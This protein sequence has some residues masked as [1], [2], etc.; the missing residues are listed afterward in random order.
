MK[1][2]IDF[3]NS[4]GHTDRV[5]IRCLSPKNTPLTELQSWGMT[6]TDKSGKVKKSTVNGYID[7][8]TGEFYRRYGKQYE[9]VTDGWEYLYELNQ[10]G[11]GI[12]FVVGHG[13]E[14]NSDITHGSNLFHESDKATLEQQQLEI[15]RI[16]QEFSKPTAVVKTK[17]SLHAYW[18]S[19]IIRIDNLATYQRRWLQYS[20]CDDTSLADPA[21]L[22]RLPGFDHLAWNGTDF[23][24]VQCELIQLNEVSYSLSDFDRILPALDVDRWC[25][26]SLEI[27]ECDATDSDMR[28]LA[29]YLPGFDSSGK[30]LKAKCPAHNGESFDSLHIDSETGGFICHAGWVY[31]SCR[32]F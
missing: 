2:S 7:L 18:A 6:Y 32:M 20:N 1:P 3:L 14:R 26:Q 29:Q 28:T 19:E 31:L 30:W 27:I 12:Y 13:G 16:T 5:H 11:Y 24:R 22:M 25:K 4:I 23:D 17:K 21:Q 10:Q 15:D 8:Q 9:P